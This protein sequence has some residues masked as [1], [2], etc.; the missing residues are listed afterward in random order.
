MSAPGAPSVTAIIPTHDRAEPLAA[1]LR[2]VVEQTYEG[3]IEILVVFDATDPWLPPLELPPNRTVRG[4]VNDRTGGPAG[5]RNAG[6]LAAAHELVALLDD[7]DTWAPTKLEEQVALLLAHPEVDL[8]GSAMV[9]DDGR[10]THARLVP[11]PPVT[12]EALLHSRVAALHTSS[13][14]ARRAAL[15]GG[16]G[17]FDEGLPRGYGE[18]YDLL[19]R[20][21]RRA[22]IPVVNRPLVTVAWSGRS[23]FL[24]RWALY[25]SALQALLERHPELATSRRGLA[26]IEGQIALALAGGGD[27]AA[28]VRWARRALGRDLRQPKAWIA[29]A[30]ALRLTSA[31]RVARV[32]GRFG[33]SI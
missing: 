16:L 8:V 29:L 24:G 9:V 25:A 10:R 26:R 7:D 28:G 27:R 12:H 15:L 30:V 33:R 2:S 19:L 11:D 31:D 23:H 14:V 1:A 22:P 3:A 13:L 20:A 6:V 4:L 5:A 18:D 17:L 21:A 32:A